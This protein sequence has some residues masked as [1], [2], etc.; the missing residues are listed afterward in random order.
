[1]FTSSPLLKGLW[2]GSAPP[3]GPLVGERFHVLVLCAV[4]YQP[5]DEQFPNVQVVHAPFSDAGFPMTEDEAETAI[6]AGEVVSHFVRKRKNVLV[7]CA[8]GRNRSGLVAGIAM[9]KIFP[10]LGCKQIVSAIRQ[11][12]GRNALSN[13]DFVELLCKFGH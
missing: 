12:R 3:T 10:R 13:E 1:M 2:I 4:E 9:A 8:Q 5:L 7:T 11:V 6:A